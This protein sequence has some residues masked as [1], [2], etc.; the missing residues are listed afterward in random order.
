MPLNGVFYWATA[1]LRTGEG[2]EHA[3][4]AMNS[5]STQAEHAARDRVLEAAAVGGDFD[6]TQIQWL[7]IT[8][9]R[10]YD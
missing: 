4:S 9:H 2:R 10:Q 6:P 3:A 7:K 5:D 1:K 8:T